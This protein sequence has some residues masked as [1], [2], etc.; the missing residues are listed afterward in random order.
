[1]NHSMNR[2]FELIKIL[3][4]QQNPLADSR[5]TCVA[6]EGGLHPEGVCIG[7]GGLRPGGLHP[8]GELGRPPHGILFVNERAVCSLLNVFLS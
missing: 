3:C 1:M 8:E 2:Q 4:A 6:M 7:V 5:I